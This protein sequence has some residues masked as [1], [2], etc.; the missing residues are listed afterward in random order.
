MLCGTYEVKLQ[1]A[2][3]RLHSMCVYVLTRVSMKMPKGIFF[4]ALI[5]VCPFIPSNLIVHECKLRIIAM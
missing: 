5:G 3:D 2:A 1:S 4:G